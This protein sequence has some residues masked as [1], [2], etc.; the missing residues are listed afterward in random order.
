M[1]A[2]ERI[3]L[4]QQ[5]LLRAARLESGLFTSCLNDMY[6]PK[7]TVTT[8]STVSKPSAQ[9]YPVAVASWP[10]F[11]ALQI[12]PPLAKRTQFRHNLNKANGL[13]PS[14]PRHPQSPGPPTPPP[15]A[16]LN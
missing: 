8:P 16:A 3:A 12:P 10:A 15:G 13:S 9:N 1:F 11:R 5:C 6:D 4:T 2:V 7:P 14:S